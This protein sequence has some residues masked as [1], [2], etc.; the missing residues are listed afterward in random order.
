MSGTAKELRGADGDEDTRACKSTYGGACARAARAWLDG[1]DRRHSRC[2]EEHRLVRGLNDRF[3]HIA[4]LRHRP[5]HVRLS[6]R[7][8]SAARGAAAGALSSAIWGSISSSRRRSHAARAT[9]VAPERGGGGAHGPHRAR[10]AS[11]PPA[12]PCS[13]PSRRAPPEQRRARCHHRGVRESGRYGRG[14][15]RPRTAAR[16][17]AAARQLRAHSRRRA[18]PRQGRP[19]SWRSPRAPAASSPCAACC[20]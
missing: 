12:P 20:P 16:A 17:A 4:H 14:R 8:A 3:A 6:A 9:R 2:S 5:A 1:K 19:G 11:A 7:A 13:A 15:H 10:R 18:A